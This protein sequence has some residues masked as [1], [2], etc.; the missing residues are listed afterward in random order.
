VALILLILVAQFDSAIKPLII[1]ASVVFSTIGVFLGISIFNMTISVMMTGIG[2]VSLAGVVVNNAIVLIDFIDLTRAR[3]REELGLA[4][5]Q[6]LPLNE[7][8][9]CIVESGRTRLR[10]VLL[11]AITTVL[12]LIPLA[13][14]YEHQ[15]LHPMSDLDPQIYFGGDNVAFW[16]PMA[17]TVIF[18]SHLR[19]VPHVGGSAG[20]VPVG[21]EIPTVVH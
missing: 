4:E 14:W 1:I 10:P 2:I 15:L 13:T 16:G 3:R 19:H 17:W 21:R 11:T 9:A 6:I 12:G 8:I 5:G 18:R 7:A 20:D